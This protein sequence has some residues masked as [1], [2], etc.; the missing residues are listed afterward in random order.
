M[1]KNWSILQDVLLH[2]PDKQRVITFYNDMLAICF[3]TWWFDEG[4]KAFIEWLK[5]NDYGDLLNGN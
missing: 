4:E 3:D 2:C 5:E 1:N